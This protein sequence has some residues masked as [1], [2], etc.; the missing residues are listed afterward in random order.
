ME[1]AG[2]HKARWFEK[3]RDR[4]LR[5]KLAL[6]DDGRPIGMIQYVPIDHSPAQGSD[7]YMILCIWVHGHKEGVG[8]QQGRGAGR[9][10]LAAA[11]EDVVQLGAKGLVAWGV[12]MPF[13]MKSSWFKKHGYRRA[14]RSGMRELVWKPLTSEAQAPRWIEEGPAPS[15][16]QGQVTVT[17]YLNG[18][19][20][21]SNLVY[22]RAKRAAAELGDRVVFKTIDTTERFSLLEHGH[23]DG[24]F[25]DGEV[26]QRGA[27]PSYEHI[28]KVIEKRLR[29]LA[30][31]G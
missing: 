29:R 7:L 18:W 23:V 9:A 31:R 22:E 3:M 16:V 24:V 17:G 19:C 13:W 2:D 28:R 8:N 12:M 11:E 5:V 26:V 21:A 10:L 20:P 6:D 1:D 15:T 4:G 25:V 14:D 30:K 27:P